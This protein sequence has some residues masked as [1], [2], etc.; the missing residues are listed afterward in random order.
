MLLVFLNLSTIDALGRIIHCCEGCPVHY[1]MFSRIPGLYSLDASHTGSSPPSCDKQ[2]CLQKLSDV[3]GGVG[4]GRNNPWWRTTDVVF[5]RVVWFWYYY[6]D[7]R[8][9]TTTTIIL[10][11]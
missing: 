8:L 5:S 10:T 4:M 1:R 11:V 3:P 9:R 6:C 7:I 2:K